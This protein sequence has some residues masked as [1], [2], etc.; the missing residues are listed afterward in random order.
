M[1]IEKAFF[2]FK[3]QWNWRHTESQIRSS[4]ESRTLCPSSKANISP[5]LGRVQR[6]IGRES[7]R[8]EIVLSTVYVIFVFACSFWSYAVKIASIRGLLHYTRMFP[9]FEQKYIQKV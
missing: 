2:E 5:K 8:E 9:L 4:V 3:S 6:S 7:I 1:W